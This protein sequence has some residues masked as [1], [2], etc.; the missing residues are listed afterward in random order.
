MVRNRA[1]RPKAPPTRWAKVTSSALLLGEAA[2]ASM[3][4]SIFV[5]TNPNALDTGN[6]LP[7]SI[8]GRLVQAPNLLASHACEQTTEDKLRRDPSAENRQQ[9]RAIG[10]LE[11]G[12]KF[13][14]H[15]ATGRPT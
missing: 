4:F 10:L 5:S 9:D 8:P 15:S 11:Q 2:I 14:C 6:S 1:R 13:I 7:R 12:S 3:T